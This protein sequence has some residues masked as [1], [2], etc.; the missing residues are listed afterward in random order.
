M[1]SRR[2]PADMAAEFGDSSFYSIVNGVGGSVAI[3][4]SRYLSGPLGAGTLAQ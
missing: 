3:K 2:N 4:A 1:P